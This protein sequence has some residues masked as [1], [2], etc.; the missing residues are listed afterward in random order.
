MKTL[1]FAAALM[2]GCASTEPRTKATS[3]SGYTGTLDI[4]TKVEKDSGRLKLKVITTRI[5]VRDGSI[6]GKSYD[7]TQYIDLGN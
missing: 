7:S 4:V 1:L 3:A 6:G 5:D 2:S